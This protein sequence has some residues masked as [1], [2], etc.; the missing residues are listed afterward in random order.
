MFVFLNVFLNKGNK[1]KEKV[2]T[3][4]I[5]R[6]ESSGEI[7]GRFFEWHGA[8]GT[9]DGGIWQWDNH[10]IYGGK[11]TMELISNTTKDLVVAL[12]N[13]DWGLAE[14]NEP[15]FKNGAKGALS[16][17]PPAGNAFTAFWGKL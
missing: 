6:N 3:L 17:K 4:E 8:N 7:Q 5:G 14:P 16:Y 1:P 15:L 12:S 13:A 11:Y 9:S 2:G 10:A